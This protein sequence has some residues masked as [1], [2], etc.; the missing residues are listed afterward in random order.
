M[1]NDHTLSDA[2][3]DAEAIV[4]VTRAGESAT[5]TNHTGKTVVVIGY[6][7]E[8]YL[9]ITATGVDA[10]GS[11]GR[12]RSPTMESRS[13]LTASWTGKASQASADTG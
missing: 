3:K 5:L 2:C 7:G 10:R 12:S 8:D 13:P 4:V 9:R 1:S 6:A 11:P